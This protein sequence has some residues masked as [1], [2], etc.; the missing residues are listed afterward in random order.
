MYART[1]ASEADQVCL[2][3][4]PRPLA[5]SR[6]KA[7]SGSSA[8]SAAAIREVLSV[9]ALSATVIRKG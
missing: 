4:R 5:D 6:T 1:C 3:A 2:S 7:T 9:L 8:A